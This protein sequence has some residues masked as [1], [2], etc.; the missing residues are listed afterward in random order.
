M[1]RTMHC[2]TGTRVAVETAAAAATA[3]ATGRAEAG[4]A[5]EGEPMERA[6]PPTP[7]NVSPVKRTTVNTG[8]MG[9]MSYAR[10]TRHGAGSV[11]K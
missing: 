11:F 9:T 1:Q 4:G 10:R 5:T 6:A 2:L 8:G 7:S 3:T